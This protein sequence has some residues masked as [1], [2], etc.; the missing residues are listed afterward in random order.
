MADE[1][2]LFVLGLA[3]SFAACSLS[4]LPMV[5][6]Y[7]AARERDWRGGLRAAATI[8][9]WRAASFAVLGGLAGSAG[10]L[11]MELVGRWE[12]PA[13]V[14]GAALLM[15]L[16]AACVAGWQPRPPCPAGGAEGRLRPRRS[17][18]LAALGTVMAVL[19]CA[20]HLGA[21][22]FIA[23]SGVGWWRGSWL[24]LAFATGNLLALLVIGGLAGAAGGIA[25]ARRR[26]RWLQVLCGLV[27]ILAGLQVAR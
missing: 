7:L 2:K 11:L 20:P 19:P 12:W 21:L 17:W 15:G 25:G 23:V 16:G 13:A 26:R 8:G 9:A 14:A 4:C 22:A 1:V 3:T 18:D 24:G 5:G 27:L 6:S 10:R